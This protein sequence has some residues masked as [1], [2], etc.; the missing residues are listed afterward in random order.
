MCRLVE[1]NMYV[2]TV[3]VGGLWDRTGR[4]GCLY[5]VLWSGVTEMSGCGHE[6]HR[7]RFF[8]VCC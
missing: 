2:C 3:R 6:P 1:S 4:G 5:G 8:N 7:R